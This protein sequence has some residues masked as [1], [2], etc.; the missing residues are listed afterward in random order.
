MPNMNALV[1]SKLLRCAL[2]AALAG[3]LSACGGGGDGGGGPV[4]VAP[5]N[6]VLTRVG[7]EAVEVAWN[8]DRYV[9][10]FVVFRDGYRLAT[11]LST[12]LVDNPGYNE[13]H[14]YQVQGFDVSGQLTASSDSG[15]ITLLP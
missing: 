1:R 14:C 3:A 8:D 13:T 2:A 15:C 11:V 4:G 5:L 10:R 12:S 7:P 6:M 9:D